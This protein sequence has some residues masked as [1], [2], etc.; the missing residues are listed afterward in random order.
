[1][2][3]RFDARLCDQPSVLV[4]SQVEDGP[5]HERGSLHAVGQT[6]LDDGLHVGTERK[7]SISR[8]ASL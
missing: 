4:F 7:L 3:A 5:R 8:P 2:P 1:M 6:G